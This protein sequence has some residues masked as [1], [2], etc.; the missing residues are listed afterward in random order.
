MEKLYTIPEAAEELRCSVVTIR[1]RIKS[2]ELKSFRNGKKYLI[3]QSQLDDFLTGG[4]KNNQSDTAE[5]MPVEKDT[6]QLM[7]GKSTPLPDSWT[8]TRKE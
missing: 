3:T 2:G 5:F 7:Q 1:R 6:A 8:K 4:T